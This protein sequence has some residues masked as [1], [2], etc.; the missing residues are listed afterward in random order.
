[1]EVLEQPGSGTEH[2]VVAMGKW[3]LAIVNNQRMVLA[4]VDVTPA[5]GAVQITWH[6]NVLHWEMQ[7]ARYIGFI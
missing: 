4:D 7:A 6:F 3:G 2:N 1:M 5:R